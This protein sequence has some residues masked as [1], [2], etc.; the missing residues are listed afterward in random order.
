MLLWQQLTSNSAGM[1]S[2]NWWHGV[3]TERKVAVVTTVGAKVPSLKGT[4]TTDSYIV[5]FVTSALEI[6]LLQVTKVLQMKK[7]NL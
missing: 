4:N 1:A 5:T 2:I 6:V 7:Y 3:C